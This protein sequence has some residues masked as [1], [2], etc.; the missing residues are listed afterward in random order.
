MDAES[1][2]DEAWGEEQPLV[3]LFGSGVVFPTTDA[4]WG[5][6]LAVHGL[7]ARAA[8]AAAQCEDEAFFR[9]IHL[10]NFVRRSVADGRAA[11]EVVRD[12][13]DPASSF[14]TDDRFMAPVLAD[15]ALLS[16]LP[17]D[18]DDE[19]DAG[20][21]AAAGEN[22][23]LRAENAALK[24][25][26]EVMRARALELMGAA[27]V[28]EEEEDSAED[29]AYYFRSYSHYG[30]HETMLKDVARMAAY[31][32]AMSTPAIAGK[33]VLDVGC[34]TGILS[35]FAAKAGATAVVAV[36]ASDIV[37]DTRQIIAT[38]GCEA[39]INVVQ[40]RIEDMASLPAPLGD[41]VDVIVS[42]WMGYG[43][44]YE[45]MLDSVIYARDK[46]LAK[47]TGLMVPSHARIFV[48]A[49]Q[50]EEWWADKVQFW[51]NVC[52]VDMNVMKHWP[53]NEAVVDVVDGRSDLASSTACL[54]TLDLYT[55]GVADLEFTR[56][57]TI[58]AQPTAGAS[59]E[60]NVYGE[61]KP[62][63]AVTWHAICLWFDTPFAIGRGQTLEESTINLDTSPNLPPTHW[64]QTMFFLETPLSVK[65]GESVSGTV[66]IT[67]HPENPREMIFTLVLGDA[68]P[69][70]YTM[71]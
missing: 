49:M 9:W 62:P 60:R 24:Q 29:S 4:L 69:R 11:A 43:L 39:T 28:E 5:H 30:I 37:P 13:T 66:A 18:D 54:H 68:A 42:E 61:L 71:Q 22:A 45:S 15:D 56:P 2:G 34:G 35:I 23:T 20:G 51:E 52:D 50:S 36:D 63:Q 19:E 8:V 65:V 32:A 59:L 14:W 31:R 57:F 55:V 64:K 17:E 33:T 16:Q 48:A 70:V 40:S 7:D 47:D 41:S 6:C 58:T 27:D 53:M 67:R 25:Q 12:A 10:V 46:W 26:L 1:D 38:N 3:D 44:L 21:A